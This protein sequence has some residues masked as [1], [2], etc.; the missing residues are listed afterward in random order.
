MVTYVYEPCILYFVIVPVY[1]S[2]SSFDGLL[3]SMNFYF[4]FYT[5]KICVHLILSSL[6]WILIS[7]F[8][9]ISITLLNWNS[10]KN[11]AWC[12][13]CY[14]KND[15][16][17]TLALHDWQTFLQRLL[18]LCM[19]VVWSF[20]RL[21]LHNQNLLSLFLSLY[22]CWL[23]NDFCWDFPWL[24]WKCHSLCFNLLLRVISYAMFLPCA[25]HNRDSLRSHYQAVCLYWEGQ[26]RHFVWF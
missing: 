12:L 8:F 3:L 24:Y 23:R 4:W 6:I 19:L 2:R 5:Q 13:S 14:G 21:I 10:G 26:V 17:V 20:E 18:D 1:F 22:R 11:C 16:Y 25:W 7:L 15:F 9:C